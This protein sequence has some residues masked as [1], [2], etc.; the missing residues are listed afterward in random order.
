[1]HILSGI[2]LVPAQQIGPPAA[3]P[4]VQQFGSV[5]HNKNTTQCVETRQIA[6]RLMLTSARKRKPL[7][8]IK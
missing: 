3:L 8:D 1:M 7:E 5:Q 4:T 6:R 2:W